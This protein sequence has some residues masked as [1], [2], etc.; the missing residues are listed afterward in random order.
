MKKFWFGFTLVLLILQ[1]VSCKTVHNMAAKPVIDV[2]TN[3][4]LLTLQGALLYSMRNNGHWP[5]D[6][7][8]LLGI[9]KTDSLE[10]ELSRFDFLEWEP[11]G[12]SLLVSYKLN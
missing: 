6:R 7:T 9:N 1:F 2:A 5:K 4:D 8:H 12:D 11:I 10:I 3:H